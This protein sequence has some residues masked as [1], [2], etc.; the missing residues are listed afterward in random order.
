MAGQVSTA[1]QEE[2]DAVVVQPDDNCPS[3]V[4]LNTG[5]GP[6]D[7]GDTLDGCESM[8]GVLVRV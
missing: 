3:L 8:L 1:A 4:K 6:G 5:E 2:L 7:G